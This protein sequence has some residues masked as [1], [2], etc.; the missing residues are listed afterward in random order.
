LANQDLN[1]QQ[2]IPILLEIEGGYSNNPYDLGGETKYGI[3]KRQYPN[4]DIPRLTSLRA[5]DIY[6]N[7]YWMKFRLN[8]IK[9]SEISRI[10]LLGLVNL[11]PES[12]GLCVQKAINK[13]G[14]NI[15]Q[16]GIVGSETIKLLNKLSPRRVADNL[17][18][19]LVKFY[20]GRVMLNK[21]QLVNLAGWI[22]RALL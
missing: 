17:R 16:D 2:A 5:S 11:K 7:D 13:L 22:R 15:Q 18:L 9:D 19:E 8:E 10:L 14:G 6:Y 21:T 20:L 3:S 12:I 4:L 1:F